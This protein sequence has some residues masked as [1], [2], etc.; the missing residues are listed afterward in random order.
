[1]SST[2]DEPY[3]LGRASEEQKRLLKQH[4]VWTKY[5]VIT[6]PEA[7]IRIKSTDPKFTKSNWILLTPLNR[8][9]TP[10]GRTYCRRRYRDRNMA[11]GPRRSLASNPHLPRLRHFL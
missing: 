3:W 8:L 9:Q 2:Q 7:N 5:V 11:Q 4:G 10:P 1:M 6:N